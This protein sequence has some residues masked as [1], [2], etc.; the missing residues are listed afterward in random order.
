MGAIP[1]ALLKHSDVVRGDH[2]ICS[3]SAVGPLAGKLISVQRPDDVFAPL[4]ALAE[5]EGY[6]VLAGVSLDKL[7][8]L[9]LA[10]KEAG[11]T[12]FRRFANDKYGTPTAVEAGGCSD[13]FDRLGEFLWPIAQSVTVGQSKWRIL[14]A[15]ETLR[16]AVA[17]IRQNPQITHCDRAD[18][19]RCNDAI[20]GGPI[21]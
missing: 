2:P 7:T 10:E 18:C 8:L 17:A 11:R 12:P 9:H 19:D 13:G 15:Q 5:V 1:A 3:F 4:A 21:R 16:R 20:L 14:P 6:I